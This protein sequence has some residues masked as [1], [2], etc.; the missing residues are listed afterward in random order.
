[1]LKMA[2]GDIILLAN[3]NLWKYHL[4]LINVVLT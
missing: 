4:F 2:P 1:M 3:S